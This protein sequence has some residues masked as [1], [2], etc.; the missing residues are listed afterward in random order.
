MAIVARYFP[1]GF[2]ATSTAAGLTLGQIR[3][4]LDI[5]DVGQPPCTHVA[6]LITQ[7][8]GEVEAR[9]AEFARARDQLKAL[10]V[11]APR[12]RIRRTATAAARS[13]PA[14]ERTGFRA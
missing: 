9:L 11:R 14:D 1:P 7:R 4:I 13:S 5:R 3:Q 10:A 2:T 8:L 6:D 12:R